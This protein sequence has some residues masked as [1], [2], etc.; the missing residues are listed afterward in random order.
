MALRKL[1]PTKIPG[2][3]ALV[4][5]SPLVAPTFTESA[6]L[7]IPIHPL[8]WKTLETLDSMSDDLLRW[9]F[10]TRAS[11]RSLK[12]AVARNKLKFRWQYAFRKALLSRGY[13]QDGQNLIS[14]LDR[15][16]LSGT[17][18]VN[19][20]NSQGFNSTD[21]DLM[22]YCSILVLALERGM[23]SSRSQARPS[24]TSR[25]NGSRMDWR[26]AS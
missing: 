26:R 15:K 12:L 4:S 19:V 23:L 10:E 25:K 20:N 5:Y 13:A 24:P 1:L 16:G 21:E 11:I 3:P 17:L 18:Q 8:R 22:K 6:I 2:F 7:S 14:N 9:T